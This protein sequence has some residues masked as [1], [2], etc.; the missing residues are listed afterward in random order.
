M[1]KVLV[2]GSGGFIGSHLTEELSSLGYR[3]KAF[4]HYNSRNSWGWLD[5][6]VR[7]ERI[8]VISGDI[9]DA[10]IVRHAMRDVEI[11]F[12]LAA[13][14]GIPY[15]YHSPE[16]YVDTN[17]KG[18]L[19]I[20]QSALDFGVKKVVLTS[21]SEVYGTAQFV[22]ITELH[23]INPQ[24]PY[25]AS[26]SAADLLGISFHKSFNLPVVIVRPFNTFGPRQSARA[27]IP[28]IVTQILAGCKKIKLGSLDPTRDLTYVE[29]TVKGF[30]KAGESKNGI[31]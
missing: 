21:T 8:E 4:V 27:V 9:R 14:I 10:D 6:S 30:I 16:A 1:K 29:D 24:S 22:P 25:A 12:H 13:L 2:T 15:S 23:P 28:T 11:V 26:K 7:K 17:I 18:T 3:V 31:G 20:L 5:S 19:N